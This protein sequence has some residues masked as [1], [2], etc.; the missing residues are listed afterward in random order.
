MNSPSHLVFV[1]FENV[2]SFD[3]DAVAQLP[4]FVKV[5]VGKSQT[6]LDMNLAMQVSRHASKVELIPVAAS[7]R[8][9]LDLVLAYHLGRAA[10]ATP[11]T[12]LHVVSKDHDFD[13][14]LAHLNG[15]GVKASRSPSF[16]D[17]PFL[18]TTKAP[19]TRKSAPRKKTAKAASPAPPPP[20]I[21]ESDPVLE[22]L[23]ARLGDG[24]PR[25]K[26]KTSLLRHIGNCY[27]NRLTPSELERK[28]DELVASGVCTLSPEGKVSY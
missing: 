20:P 11:D 26:R 10:A 7:G 22:K 21:A 4:V 2:P 1:D 17:L 27:G 15:A 23:A 9:A 12:T 28:L 18:Q 3:L 25:P 14:L 8:N 19:S 24:G 16:A 13:P 5:L 6:K